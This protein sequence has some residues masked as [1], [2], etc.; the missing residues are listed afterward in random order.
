MQHK[1]IKS[2][3]ITR[4]LIIQKM[5]RLV[6]HFL[7]ATTILLSNFAIF[8]TPTLAQDAPC[9]CAFSEQCNPV[10]G[11]SGPGAGNHW[12]AGRLLDPTDLGS[13]CEYNPGCGL[14]CTKCLVGG[15]ADKY[16]KTSQTLC[17]IGARCNKLANGMYAGERGLW[18][19]VFAECYCNYG[20]LA[21]VLVNIG[22][23]VIGT[24]SVIMFCIGG[25]KYITAKNDPE[26]LSDAKGTLT[27]AVAGFLLVLLSISVMRLLEGQL[28]P[29]G[30]HFL[31]FS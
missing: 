17:E 10:T 3:S 4:S 30:I 31:K 20:Q 28:S 12:C 2:L 5:I 6:L 24:L 26:K 11:A 22:Y 8:A 27:A 29:W 7:F 25:F 21:Q 16:L 9:N 15:A 1:I 23:T 13:N 14:V 18:S 19:S